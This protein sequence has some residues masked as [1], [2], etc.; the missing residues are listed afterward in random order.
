MPCGILLFGVKVVKGVIAH[1]GELVV[2][3]I[4]LVDSC[5]TH[6]VGY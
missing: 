4:C 1:W 2:K 3:V 5:R 6:Y